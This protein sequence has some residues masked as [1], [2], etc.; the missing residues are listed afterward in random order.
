[1]NRLT[2]TTLSSAILMLAAC[3][4]GGEAPD[5]A[6]ERESAEG[7]EVAVVPGGPNA[8]SVWG[9]IAFKTAGNNAGHDLVTTHLAMYDAVMA[10]ANT[11]KPYAVVP[12]TPGAG[13]GAVGMN[14]AA[15]EAAYRVLKGLF[16]AAGAVY[17]AQYAADIGALP[18][19]DAKTR[20]QAIGSEV[21]AGM[22]AL[23]AN[24][25]RATVLPPYVAGTLP[26]Q[27]RGTNPVNRIA[28]FVKPFATL[29][30][31]QFRAPGPTALSS[32]AYA[33]DLNEV[34]L[35]ASAVSTTRSAEQT[36]LARFETENPSTY[37]DRN[38][39]QF[40]TASSDLAESARVAAMLWTAFQD[41]I[42]AC[43]ESKYHHNF[44]RPISAIQLADTDGNPA[45][46][47]D[48]AWAPHVPTPNHPEYP[49]AHG[50][51]T[52]ALMET[53][54]T[55]YGTK[56]VRFTFTSSVA[57]TG[58]RSYART[59]DKIKGVIDARVWGGMHF[60]T[61]AEHGAEL[62]KNVAKWVVKHHFTPLSK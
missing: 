60:R 11:H 4:G 45:T 30:H 1:M 46:Q 13:L 61:S 57:G 59:D 27:F 6:T 58:P 3:G 52:G 48:P 62:G 16:P 5:S 31:S 34:K 25:G 44:W 40:I 42:S 43:F 51:A 7:R 38:L 14:A 17:E 28:P 53:A 12:S 22:L 39:R 32:D 37:W 20:G 8:I 24:D 9:E 10:I 21:A 33:S 56:K 15:V 36:E 18:D 2:L 35:V 50:C 49:A 55:F 41:A 23:R 47:A 29:S 26:G 54:R 19:G